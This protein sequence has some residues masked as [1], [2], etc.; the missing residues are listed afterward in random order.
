MMSISY[1]EKS[2]ATRHFKLNREQIN[3]QNQLIKF[4]NIN[5]FNPEQ[6]NWNFPYYDCLLVQ[7]NNKVEWHQQL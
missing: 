3:T 6:Y 4:L 5:R 7:N 1:N 2:K